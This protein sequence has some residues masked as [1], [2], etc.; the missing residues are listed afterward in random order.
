[1]VRDMVSTWR[2]PAFFYG[3]AYMGSLEPTV[4]AVLCALFGFSPF[5]VCMGSVAVGFAILASVWYIGRRLGGPWGA[6]LSLFFAITGGFFW[7]HFVAS[8]RGGYPLAALLSLWAIYGGVAVEYWDSGKRLRLLPTAALGVLLGLAFWNVWHALPA[9]VL[10][11]VALLARYRLRVFSWRFLLVFI[12]AFLAAS[13]PWWVWN[14]C[15]GWESLQMG[16]GTSFV[17]GWKRLFG[18]I[19]F[20]LADFHGYRRR[21]DEF[22]RTSLPWAL[23]GTWAVSIALHALFSR[24]RRGFF[25]LTAVAFC[26]FLFSLFL[27]TPYGAA[28]ASRYFI[29]LVLTHYK[30]Q[31]SGYISLCS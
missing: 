17:L 27:F 13:S 16:T 19:H 14:A 28:R 1:M 10:A 5:A 22:W 30:L 20:I 8:P 12:A 11:G 24:G 18:T 6:A 4:S 21:S 25:V 23:L 2:I 29:P 7:I 15:H 3:Q 26:I 31:F 9:F